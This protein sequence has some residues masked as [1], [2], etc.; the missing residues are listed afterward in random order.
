MKRPPTPPTTPPTIAPVCDDEVVEVLLLLLE[1]TD[2][3]V[4]TEP[5]E[6][7]V[8]VSTIVVKTAPFALVDITVA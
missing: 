5:A 6:R 4:T 7:T 3:D 1:E 2:V 8:R